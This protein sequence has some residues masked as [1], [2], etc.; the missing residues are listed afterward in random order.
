[1][2]DVPFLESSVE[3]NVDDLSLAK[4][5]LDSWHKLQLRVNACYDNRL[6][7]MFKDATRGIKQVI[8]HFMTF[9]ACNVTIICA[10][11]K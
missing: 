2:F 5:V 7:K 4:E 10:I 3:K 1:M 6:G 8:L 11:L 9:I